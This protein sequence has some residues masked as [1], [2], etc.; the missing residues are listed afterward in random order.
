MGKARVRPPFCM[1]NRMIA[2]LD[3]VYWMRLVQ[4]GERVRVIDYGPDGVHWS[5]STTADAFVVGGVLKSGV[6]AA[7]NAATRWLVN[8]AELTLKL[9]SRRAA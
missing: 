5:I 9:A 1:G 2:Q 6:Q 4:L 8:R 3:G 7:A